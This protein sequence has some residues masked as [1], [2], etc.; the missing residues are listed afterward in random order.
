MKYIYFFI[1]ALTIGLIVNLFLKK[2]Q[3][4]EEEETYNNR[5]IEMANP[6]SDFNLSIPNPADVITKSPMYQEAEV[7]FLEEYPKEL[8]YVRM[9]ELTFQMSA[10]HFFLSTTDRVLKFQGEPDSITTITDHCYFYPNAFTD[11]LYRYHYPSETFLIANEIA[12]LETLR[13]IGTLDWAVYQDS[14]IWSKETTFDTFY[15]HF[16]DACDQAKQLSP[17]EKS[18]AVKFYPLVDKHLELY[19]KQDSLVK[20][21]IVP[22]C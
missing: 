4:Y 12:Y 20:L 18:I 8:E 3:Q 6:L 17:T 5:L 2:K 13:C 14:I 22:N 11:T 9:E 16:P 1:I 15:P 7:L 19:F 21:Q 10:I